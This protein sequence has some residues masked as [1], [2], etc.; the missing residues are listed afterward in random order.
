MGKIEH[1][2]F[3]NLGGWQ[4]FDNTN[5]FFQSYNDI[6]FFTDARSWT[7]RVMICYTN[8]KIHDIRFHIEGDCE[9]AHRMITSFEEFI[10]TK[11]NFKL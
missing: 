6:S 10:K 3:Y 11:T 1:K 5:V 8:D 2:S 7:V 9:F 4:E